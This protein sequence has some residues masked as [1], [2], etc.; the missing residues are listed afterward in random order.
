MYHV[1]RCLYILLLAS[2]LSGCSSSVTPRLGSSSTDQGL[3]PGNSQSSL[4]RLARA[5]QE[6][7]EIQE[8]PGRTN[9]EESDR[10]EN[11][12]REL[13]KQADSAL[14]ADGEKAVPILL[15]HLRE[16]NLSRLCQQHLGQ[17]GA[18][19]APQ[20]LEWLRSHP[21]D[22]EVLTPVFIAQGKSAG[23]K[24]AA[25]TEGSDQERALA[26][27]I[28]GYRYS[29]DE[30]HYA[31][32]PLDADEIKQMSAASQKFLVAAIQKEKDEAVRINLVNALRNFEL[33]SEPSQEV[34]SKLIESDSSE[35]LRIAAIKTAGSWLSKMSPTARTGIVSAMTKTLSS[36]ESVDVRKAVAVALK[37]AKT[38]TPD[39]LSALRQAKNDQSKDVRNAAIEAL[40]DL[41]AHSPSANVEDIIEELKNPDTVYAGLLSVI[42]AGP[43]AKAAIPY[44]LS[45][46]VGRRKDLVVRALIATESTSPQI[47]QTM[48]DA[49]DPSDESSGLNVN[50]EVIEF[51]K[52]LDAK[53]A[54]P[55]IPI[56]QRIV[57]S[58]SGYNKRHAEECLKTL[59][60]TK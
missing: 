12:I 22:W 11:E 51:F 31:I 18:A 36:D 54:A 30:R 59:G 44:V 16:Q 56:L 48:V 10:K 19:C 27:K 35:E 1:T 39:V 3:M 33:G 49:M 37:T 45:A 13:Y 60:V 42:S 58:P 26:A 53:T 20:C 14:K 28:L 32:R 47:V 5:E 15:S 38:G 50:R 46:N 55:A 43:R 57:T 41:A 6:R 4:D 40:G 2:V 23:D 17:I 29:G 52:R 9:R 24:L 7:R 25:M 21:Q 34:L 8:R